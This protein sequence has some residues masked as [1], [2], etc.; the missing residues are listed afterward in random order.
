[1]PITTIQTQR[2]AVTELLVDLRGYYTRALAGPRRTD[3]KLQRQLD[4]LN[5][6]LL[7]YGVEEG[8]LI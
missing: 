8:D 6:V 4:L 3:F 2:E 1:M 7:G 5:D